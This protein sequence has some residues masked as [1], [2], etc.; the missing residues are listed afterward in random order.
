MSE[1]SELRETARLEAF[2]D[3]VFA[4]GATIL[5]L[6]LRLPTVEHVTTGR[7][8]RAVLHQW[9]SYFAFALSF[10]T[11]L[12]M[13]INH[14]ARM[15]LVARIDGLL[16]FANGFVLFMIATL[17]FP[18]AI[19][20]KYL[21]GS[22]ARGAVFVYAMFVLTQSGAWNLFMFA[23]KPERGLLQ[24]GVPASLI[25]RTRRRVGLGLVVYAAAAGL[26]LL[27]AYLGLAIITAMWAFWGAVAYQ[28][29]NERRTLS[30]EA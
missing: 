9:P 5:V 11:I 25:A 6:D 3:G 15:G 12:I 20:G 22:G 24:P 19:V 8:I 21:T 14:H 28:A 18:T 29:L 13:W 1:P 16:M 2:S 27:N 26:A 30:T 17:S 4:I 10:A 7:L 23:M